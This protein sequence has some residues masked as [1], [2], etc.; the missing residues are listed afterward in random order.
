M[1]PVDPNSREQQITVVDQGDG[2]WHC[3]SPLR[4]RVLDGP[5]EHPASLG[6]H[7]VLL[8]TDTTI[9]WHGDPR[10]ADRWGEDHALC[11]RIPP[12]NRLLVLASGVNLDRDFGVPASPVVN[13]ADTVGE[14]RVLPGLTAKVSVFGGSSPPSN[15]AAG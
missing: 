13:R 8:W 9:E 15:H 4:C 7:H 5:A 3:P 11:H 6:T 10:F 2:W 14:A 1:G 12:T